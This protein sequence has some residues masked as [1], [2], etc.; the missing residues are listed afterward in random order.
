[1]RDQGETFE[2]KDDFFFFPKSTD[3]WG[4]LRGLETGALLLMVCTDV[5]EMGDATNDPIP[6]KPSCYQKRGQRQGKREGM[7]RDVNK[8]C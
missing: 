5:R 7:V 3:K 2:R 4:D 6:L 8:A 1:M